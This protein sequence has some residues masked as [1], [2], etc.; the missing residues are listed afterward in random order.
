MKHVLVVDDE[1]AIREAIE[2]CFG[3]NHRL[4]LMD[5]GTEATY[6]LHSEN[7]DLVLTDYDMRLGDGRSV[8]NSCISLGIPVVVM[9]GHDPRKIRKNLPK[10]VPIVDK[11]KLFD[12]E[13]LDGLLS[14][15]A[16]KSA[17]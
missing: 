1:F 4:T 16:D 11:V 3:D 8:V 13:D 6:L 5:S 15:E 12:H 2:N 17:L 10:G 7:F 9:T 14:H